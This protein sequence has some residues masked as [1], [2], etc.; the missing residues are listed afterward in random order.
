MRTVMAAVAVLGLA[1]GCVA[2]GLSTTRTYR[3][4][5]RSEARWILAG[6][7]VEVLLGGAMIAG[8]LESIANP[9]PMAAGE[10]V[11]IGAGAEE[12]GAAV[13]ALVLGGVLVAAGAGDVLGGL[14]QLAT[15]DYLIGEPLE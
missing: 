8:G 10:P 6:G 13:A 1:T 9:E 4:T 15:N 5:P 7:L 2:D 14:Y 3:T 11:D 12:L